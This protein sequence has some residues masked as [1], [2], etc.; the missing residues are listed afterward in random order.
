MVDGMDLEFRP[1]LMGLGM[2]EDGEMVKPKGRANFGMQ[3]ETTMKV[4]N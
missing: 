1:G 4:R 3:M 2:K